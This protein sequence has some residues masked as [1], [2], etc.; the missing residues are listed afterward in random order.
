MLYDNISFLDWLP[1]Y[2]RMGIS[3]WVNDTR[4]LNSKTTATQIEWRDNSRAYPRRSSGCGSVKKIS[5]DKQRATR[6]YSVSAQYYIAD[7]SKAYFSL[8]ADM[9]SLLEAQSHISAKFLTQMSLKLDEIAKLKRWLVV[10]M[11]ASAFVILHGD[12]IRESKSS[13][14]LSSFFTKCGISKRLQQ[15]SGSK[16][17][18]IPSSDIISC[19][20]WVKNLSVRNIPHRRVVTGLRSQWLISS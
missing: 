7:L 3:P 13:L 2:D 14:L 9:S 6:Q 8:F 17:H 20:D 4:P 1:V 15:H 19:K 16:A 18:K 5:T 11:R 12:T 10:P